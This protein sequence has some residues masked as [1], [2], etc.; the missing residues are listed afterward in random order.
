MQVRLSV[1]APGAREP[2][3][4]TIAA[5]PGTRLGEVA[6]QLRAAAIPPPTRGA[7]DKGQRALSLPTGGRRQTRKK[8]E[9]S[10]PV[11]G[12]QCRVL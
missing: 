10:E 1:V 12:D 2:V 5:A 11:V 6:D 4:V 8:G 9:C 7:A 3:D